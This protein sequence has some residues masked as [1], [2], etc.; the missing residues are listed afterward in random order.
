L[1]NVLIFVAVL[2]SIAVI[3]HAYNMGYDA[4]HWSGDDREDRN[5]PKP[6]PEVPK[7]WK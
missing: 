4:G 2:L 1:D 7:L 3:A 6:P 5:E